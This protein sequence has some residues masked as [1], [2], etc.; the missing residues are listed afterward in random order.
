M[1]QDADEIQDLSQ[2]EFMLG[3]WG[4]EFP[5][6][7]YYES[8]VKESDTKFTGTAYKVMGGDSTITETLSLEILD[9]GYYQGIYYIALPVLQDTTYFLYVAGSNEDAEFQNPEHDFPQRIAY[10]KVDADRLYVLVD[11]LDPDPN[12]QLSFNFIRTKND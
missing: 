11:N 8:W 4:A 7:A 5:D 12:R 10:R 3:T 6:G 1:A 2:F 9:D